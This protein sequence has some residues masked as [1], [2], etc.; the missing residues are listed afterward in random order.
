M[1]DR[2]IDFNFDLDKMKA[3]IDSGVISFPIGL[4]GEERRAYIRSRLKEIDNGNRDN[5]RLTLPAG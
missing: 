1:I 3:S 5:T 2:D 4:T